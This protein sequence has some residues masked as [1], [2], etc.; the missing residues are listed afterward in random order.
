M[1]EPKLGRAS[2]WLPRPKSANRPQRNHKILAAAG[3]LAAV[4]VAGLAW[5]PGAGSKPAH[6][7]QQAAP[8][9]PRSI[10][11]EFGESPAERRRYA[12]SRLHQDVL[13][14][15]ATLQIIAA[16]AHEDLSRDAVIH[17]EHIIRIASQ[18]AAGADS[19]QIRTGSSS[20]SGR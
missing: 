11:A 12:M 13:Q 1:S 17:L 8:A 16:S 20:P 2:G 6:D 14:G 5:L 18:S 7:P 15:V 9:E 3:W 19:P 10:S 4:S